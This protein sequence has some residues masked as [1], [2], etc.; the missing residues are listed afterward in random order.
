MHILVW[1]NEQFEEQSDV[2]EGH[3]TMALMT[4]NVAL[5]VVRQYMPEKIFLHT[6][7]LY[8]ID[9]LC[10][11]GYSPPVLTDTVTYE[12]QASIE[13]VYFPDLS[14]LLALI[15]F[16]GRGEFRKYHFA[17]FVSEYE[18][19]YLV[20][21]AWVIEVAKDVYAISLEV[22]RLYMLD[23]EDLLADRQADEI[24]NGGMFR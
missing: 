17:T 23:A 24:E 9:V 14:R 22:I 7:S 6:P 21:H 12:M 5:K 19:D 13:T 18:F 2:F 15:N 11:E 1:D 10:K 16:L 8:A 3:E 4:K 20:R